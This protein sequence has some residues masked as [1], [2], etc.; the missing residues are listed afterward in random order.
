MGHA[1]SE[2]NG[3]EGIELALD[4]QLRGT[5]S[6]VQGMRDALGREIAVE[7]AADAA[8]TT[9]SDVVL[10]IDRY[11]T[12]ITERA[13]AAGAEE[14]H[15]KAAIAMMIDPRTGELLALASV[16]TY[17]PNDPSS[18]AESGARN[19]ADHRRVRA[20]VDDEDVHDRGRAGRGVG[21]ARRPLRLPDGADDGREV[22]DPRHAPARRADR[23]RG[24]QGFEQHRRDEDRAQAGSRPAGRR[25]GAVRL[26]TADGRRAARRTRGRGAALSKSG[27]TSGS[28][29]SRSVRG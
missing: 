14:H 17:N 7:G 9:G 22:L 19:R 15:A 28:P 16:P 25:A 12:F 1:G 20:R 11:L 29:T 5:S 18:A 6:S 4:R 10:T 27:A 23:G 2:G 8:S 26:R 24:V 21:Q 3:L 13:L